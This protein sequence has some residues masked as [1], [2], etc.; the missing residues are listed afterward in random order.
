MS[1]EGLKGLAFLGT[2]ATFLYMWPAAVIAT[3]GAVPQARPPALPQRSVDVALPPASGATLPVAAGQSLQHA[4]DIAQ[5]GDTIALQHGAVFGPVVLPAKPGADWIVIRTDTPD[6]DL[7]AP[8]TRV[9]PEDAPK[10]AVVEAGSGSAIQ[11]AS[12]AHHYR[13]IGIEV[14]PSAGVALKNLID[15]GSEEQTADGVPHHIVIDRC[16][17]HGDAAKGTRRG[18]ALNSAQTA[19]VDSYFSDFKEVGAD[20]QGIAGWTG[21]GPFK[22]VDNY[23]EGAG[24]NILFGG[25][26]PVETN[27]VPSDIEIR[28]NHLVKPTAWRQGDPS[29][30][31][32][33]WTVKNLLELKNARRVLV[34]G[35]V[36]EQNWAD[37]QTGY[38]ILFT[39]RNQ[40]G[41]APWSSVEDITFSNNIVR[42]SGSGINVLG[43][44]DLQPSGPTQRVVI[45]NNLFDDIGKAWGGAGTLLQ[46][47]DG[48]SDV[49]FTHNTAFQTGNVI[50][51][52]GRVQDSFV[53]DD[54]IAPS[55]QYGI[56]GT[57]T[58]S[59]TVTLDKYF[60]GAAVRKN[61]IP[62][63]V[64]SQYPGDNFYPA[65]LDDVGFVGRSRGDYRLTDTSPYRRAA[66]DGKD[67]G[68]DLQELATA[69]TGAAGTRAPEPPVD[70][71]PQRAQPFAA[72]PHGGRL[73][74]MKLAFWG[75]AGLLA[76]TFFG[77]PALIAVLARGARSGRGRSTGRIEIFRGREPSVTVVV[78]AQDEA[79]RI[80]ARIANLLALDYPPERLDVI[81]AS[82]GST[83][84]TVEAA[85]AFADSR[86][87]VM[88]FASRRGKAAVLNEAVAKARGSIVVL[89]D[90]RQVFERSALRA[91]VGPFVDPAVGA[92]SGELVLRPERG[93]AVAHGV[94]FYWRY[95]K[96]IR[97]AE[98]AFDST[99]GATGAI[100]AIRRELFRPIPDDTVLDDVLIP[101][102]IA[103]SGKRVLFETRAR[104]FDHASARAGDELRRKVRT[105]AGTFQLFARHPWTLVPFRNRLWFQT[106]SHK[107]LRL[108]L[109][110]LLATTLVSS[111]ALAHAPAY[112]AAVGAQAA[113]YLAAAIG[114]LFRHAAWKPPLVS[115]PYVICLLAWATVVAAVRFATGR[116]TVT[117]ERPA[118]GAARPLDAVD[119]LSL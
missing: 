119:G 33:P 4:V 106:V 42:H 79:P 23:I 48:A 13:F 46:I 34:D 104:A 11:T 44:D 27:L 25:A 40:D 118:H 8:G 2:V 35:N 78:V 108:L 15:L 53:F 20:S 29:Y 17:V 32:T 83:D 18:V 36:L 70:R 82:D 63:A 101:L 116:Q 58:P 19:I 88:A 95:E 85:E 107:A 39:V 54:N 72:P 105:I 80:Q 111:V 102:R 26:D 6:G 93:T 65:S 89:A 103:A 12:G 43:H 5:P 50:T 10:L 74:P 51:T 97:R 66:T 99:V 91:L 64:A 92:V 38:A 45:R 62:G 115:G 21:P 113:L 100:Y 117:W 3:R 1:A 37:A 14:R 109:P 110:A 86:V 56:T 68:V 71:R 59:G 30:E 60:P 98:S 22:I 61:V 52:E 31:G 69:G 55:N 9:V 49:A 112:R 81:V 90:A 96:W 84:A 87:A 47:L 57:G 41:T 24:E 94:G 76:Y 114:F 67:V 7:P 77:Y 75:S 28:R 73:S 16:F